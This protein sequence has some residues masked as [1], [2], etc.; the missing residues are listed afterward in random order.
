MGILIR[1]PMRMREKGMR[2]MISDSEMQLVQGVDKRGAASDLIEN[3]EEN[4]V[5][6]GRISEGSSTMV[7]H[8]A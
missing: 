8:V 2:R 1:K 7:S 4:V 5:K 6:K 3:V